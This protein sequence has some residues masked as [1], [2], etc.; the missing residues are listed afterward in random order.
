MR[1]VQLSV[2]MV[3][4]L[5]PAPLSFADRE[6]G[7]RVYVTASEYGQFYAKS[8]PSESYGLKGTTKV[9]QVMEEEDVLIQTYD[10]YSPRIFQYQ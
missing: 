4:L 2:L 6:A 10:W 3:C 5:L 9:Y 1:I 7:N 8:V